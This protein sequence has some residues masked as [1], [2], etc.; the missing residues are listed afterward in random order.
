MQFLRYNR[1]EHE[2]LLD[3][4]F[5]DPRTPVN[6]RSHAALKTD[7]YDEKQGIMGMMVDK[8]QII[9]LS[10]AIRVEERGVVSCKYPHRLHVRSDYQHIGSSFIDS[11]WDITVHT[12]LQD[13]GISNIYCTFNEGNE[14]AFLWAAVRHRRR[15]NNPYLNSVGEVIMS[16][17]WRVYPHLIMEMHVPQYLI[18]SSPGASWF[19]PWR[20]ESP[21]S[22]V[23]A[24]MLNRHLEVDHH[25]WVM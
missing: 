9:A 13:C 15:V 10:S 22:S 12:W 2:G 20:D 17:P 25:G 19:Y 21:L 3:Q 6:N 14:R 1:S 5:T 4:Y 18:Y 24:D 11:H 23:T 16:R 7:L 8:D